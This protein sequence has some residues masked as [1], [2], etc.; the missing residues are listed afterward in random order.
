M[1]HSQHSIPWP[2][3]NSPR[4]TALI[5]MCLAGHVVAH[6]ASNFLTKKL[7]HL[8]PNDSDIGGKLWDAFAHTNFHLVNNSHVD[9]SLSGATLTASILCKTKLITAWAGDSRAVL[10]RQEQNAIRACDLTVDHKPTLPLELERILAAGGRV[11]PLVVCS[12]YIQ[13]HLFNS[14]V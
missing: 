5:L 1:V 4:V 3:L 12:L 13:C 14:I 6:A 9:C 11:Q 10:A 7:S 2:L 8:D